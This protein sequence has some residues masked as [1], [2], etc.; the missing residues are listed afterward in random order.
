MLKKE[1]DEA[2]AADLVK[3]V[4]YSGSYGSD[5]IGSGPGTDPLLLDEKHPII[6]AFVG[7]QPSSDW[8]TGFTYEIY[9]HNAGVVIQSLPYDAGLTEEY[10]FLEQECTFRANQTAGSGV[11]LPLNY[12]SVPGYDV[13]R[14]GN[15]TYPIAEWDCHT[16][17]W[18]N[19]LESGSSISPWLNFAI[20]SPTMMLATAIAVIRLV[21]L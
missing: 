21:L 7:L 5:I 6:S 3:S 11:V 15:E 19:L 4:V 2:I 12:P 9:P 13:F 8:F 16:H 14:N 18:E 1:L 20:T 10:D 17:E